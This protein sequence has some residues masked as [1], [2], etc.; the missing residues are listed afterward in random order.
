MRHRIAAQGHLVPM[1][2]GECIPSA[3]QQNVSMSTSAYK[4]ATGAATAAL[5]GIIGQ[6]EKSGWEYGGRLA[7]LADGKYAYVLPTTDKSSTSVGV[8]AGMKEGTRIPAGTTD[9]GMYHTYPT[10]C[11]ACA[12]LI[13]LIGTKDRADQYDAYNKTKHDRESNLR[14]AT[15]ENAVHAVGAAIVMF[16]AQFGAEIEPRHG[17]QAALV[18][19]STFS[20]ATD[21][22]RHPRSCYVPE[23]TVR[24]TRLPYRP[25]T[26]G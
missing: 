11:A 20:L 22:A 17:E 7:Q 6:S 16:F 21:F 14:Y 24:Q 26:G 9:A 10:S 2:Q 3:Q 15:L 4:S 1:R 19:Q 8:D 12:T 23:Y 13:T 5:D 18:I 25:L